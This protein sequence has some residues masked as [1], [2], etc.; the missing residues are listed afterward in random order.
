L[1]K[2]IDLTGRKFGKLKVLYQ[3]G[4]DKRGEALWKCQCDCGNLHLVKG[5]LLRMG[6]SKSCGCDKARLCKEANLIH[7]KSNIRL[8]HIWLHMK[9]RCY[10]IKAHNYKYYGARGITVCDEWKND[11]MAFYD[12]AIVNGYS[13]DLSID[14]I[15]VNGNYEPSNCRWITMTEQQSNRRNSIKTNF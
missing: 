2:P 15:N 6:V 11:F 13:D 10:D 5:S 9:R 4:T 1:R 3:Q 7:G 8:Y 14:R 12:W